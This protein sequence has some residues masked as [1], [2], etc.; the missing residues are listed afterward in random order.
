[1]TEIEVAAWQL[2]DVFAP[3]I[4]AALIIGV[5][6]H[7]IND[8]QISPVLDRMRRD[9]GLA[10]HLHMQDIANLYEGV[11]TSSDAKELLEKSL[12][13]K[14]MIHIVDP[15][16]GWDPHY[17]PQR[18]AQY[19]PEEVKSWLSHVCEDPQP[20]KCSNFE[21]Q[22]FSRDEIVRWLKGNNISSVFPFDREEQS[23]VAAEDGRSVKSGK[24]L[25]KTPLMWAV[26]EA[27]ARY[28]GENVR[29]DDHSTHPINPDV[30]EWLVK[31]YDCVR[32]TMADRIA[33]IIRPSWASKGK[34][35]ES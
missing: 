35:P 20:W 9:Y 23:V 30:A 34:P 19:D 27:S 21:V 25:N 31:N 32:K 12:Q 10:I 15:A 14:A 8:G 24:I 17:D 26:E 4:V 6:P 33:T 5:N 3:K 7:E 16:S 1:M 13:S 2:N 11:E 29:E 28:W 22:E 18:G